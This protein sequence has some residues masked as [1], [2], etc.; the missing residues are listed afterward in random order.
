MAAAYNL[1]E[2]VNIRLSSSLH[3]IVLNPVVHVKG[4]RESNLI[5]NK[6]CLKTYFLLSLGLTVGL[7]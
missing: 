7:S 4:R 5:M 6:Q 2:L 3:H 1:Q